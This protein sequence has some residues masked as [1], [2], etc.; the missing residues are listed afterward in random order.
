MPNVFENPKQALISL[1]EDTTE[2]IDETIG[3]I[4]YPNFNSYLYDTSKKLYV[5]T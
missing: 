2:M 4:I 3:G 5:V 1:K